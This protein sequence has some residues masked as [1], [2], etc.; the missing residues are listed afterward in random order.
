MRISLAILVLVALVPS[1]IIVLLELGRFNADRMASL[2]RSG[3]QL[4]DKLG[5]A[6]E[7]RVEERLTLLKA[8]ATSPLLKSHDYAAFYDHAR[9]LIDPSDGVLVLLDHQ[10]KMLLSTAVAFGA[11]LPAPTDVE[12]TRRAIETSKPQVSDLFVSPFTGKPVLSIAYAPPG[13]EV[14][15]RLTIRSD[16]LGAALKAR[17]K[18]MP[19]SASFCRLGVGT[20]AP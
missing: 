18:S 19:P 3:H 16:M 10:P 7:A 17:R 5:A 15:A 12:L 4:A 11:P 8:L 13:S 20:G 14:V 9:A 2:E 6:V 1:V